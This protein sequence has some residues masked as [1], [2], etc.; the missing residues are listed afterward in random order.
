MKTTTI[1]QLFNHELYVL[2][3]I[4]RRIV[5]DK[6]FSFIVIGKMRFPEIIH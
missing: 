4:D 3:S 6:I 1:L 2:C 5:F